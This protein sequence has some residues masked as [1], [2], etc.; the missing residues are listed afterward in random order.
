MVE[1]GLPILDATVFNIFSNTDTSFIFFLVATSEDQQTRKDALPYA[2][3]EVIGVPEIADSFI[4]EWEYKTEGRLEL[5]TRIYDAKL[6]KA[7]SDLWTDRAVFY[8]NCKN[9]FISNL[10]ARG[11][12]SLMLED[13]NVSQAMRVDT[14]LNRL[15][16]IEENTISNGGEIVERLK[17]LYMR[18]LENYELL[19]KID[20]KLF[21]T[22]EEL[23]L[24]RKGYDS[25]QVEYMKSDSELRKRIES[26]SDKYRTQLS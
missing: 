14:I 1:I 21:P 12:E 7:I 25:E 11:V 8:K 9:D 13:K 17:V 3:A 26:I 23:E 20:K 22:I 6:I 5:R 4:D 10:I 15:D 18:H 24:R 2:N 16:K 19:S